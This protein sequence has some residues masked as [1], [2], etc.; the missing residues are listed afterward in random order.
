MQP[1]QRNNFLVTKYHWTRHFILIS[2][3]LL[4]FLSFTVYGFYNFFLKSQAPSKKNLAHQKAKNS[5]TKA[6]ITKTKSSKK[7]ENKPDSTKAEYKPKDIKIL[8]DLAKEQFEDPKNIIHADY[9]AN[10]AIEILKDKPSYEDPLAMPYMQIITSYAL[11]EQQIEV[12]FQYVC[13][14]TQLYLYFKVLKKL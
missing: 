7:V 11:D 2:L 5:K 13:F 6:K 1:Y 8:L 10:K 4:G 14:F 12:L 9:F 3:G